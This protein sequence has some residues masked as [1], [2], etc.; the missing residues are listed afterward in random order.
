MPL[1]IVTDFPNHESTYSKTKTQAKPAPIIGLTLTVM[2]HF[3]RILIIILFLITICS[4]CN[5]K[6]IDNIPNPSPKFVNYE[7]FDGGKTSLDDLKGQILLIDVWA[8]WC[9]PCLAELPALSKLQ[10]KYQGK[11]IEFVSISVD[12]PKYRQKW[13]DM[14]RDQEL[15]GIHLI[16][17]SSMQS[18]FIKDYKFN[19]IPRFILI[20][21]DGNIINPNAPRPSDPEL[22]ILLE[23]LLD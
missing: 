5:R 4:G 1:L 21:A 22:D 11:A 12:E 18:K 10:L 13:K 17:D 3:M 19:G 6:K 2:W 16:A 14:I 8:T 15:K 23:S 20:D 7:N 9:E